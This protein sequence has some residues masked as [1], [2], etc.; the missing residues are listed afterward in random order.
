MQIVDVK[1]LKYKDAHKLSK[2]FD[3][4]TVL[5]RYTLEFQEKHIELENAFHNILHELNDCFPDFTEH[6][7]C[8]DVE[9]ESQSE[10]NIVE[11]G[12]Y[13]DI[14][15]LLEHLVIDILT[16]IEPEKRFSGTT[17]QYEDDH[18]KFD[19]FINVCNPQITLFA[20]HLAWSTISSIICKQALTKIFQK[21]IQISSYIINYEGKKIMREALQDQF[22]CSAHVI[23]QALLLLEE[24]SLI[25]EFDDDE[26]MI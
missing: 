14:P 13:M 23:E 19:I 7:C 2:Y 17:C 6:R 26:V 5:G 8:H 18:N 16:T 1:Y 12:N 24:F 22:D 15:H 21:L 11:Y 4:N 3:S 10:Y 25:S 20:F 9:L